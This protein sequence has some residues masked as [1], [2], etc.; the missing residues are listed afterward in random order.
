MNNILLFIYLFIYYSFYQFWALDLNTK[1]SKLYRPTTTACKSTIT[2]TTPPKQEDFADQPF[3]GV[4][5]MI[6]E[7]SSSEFDTKWQKKDH[8]R[9]VNHVALTGPVVQTKWSNVPLTFDASVGDSF[10]NAMS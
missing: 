8:Y 5:H 3:Q 10:S 4:F 2:T 6:T 1:K 9:R 7:G